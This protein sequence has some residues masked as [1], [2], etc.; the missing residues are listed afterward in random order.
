MQ[1][2]RRHAHV[3]AR[4]LTWV[5][6]LRYRVLMRGRVQFGKGFI[7]NHRFVVHGPGR[8][9]IGNGVNAWAHQEPTRLITTSRDAVIL[10]GDN[11]R[12]NGPTL[13]ARERVEVGENCILGS[14]VVFDSDYHSVHRDRRTTPHALVRTQPVRVGP[15]VWLAGQSAVLPGVSVGKD[16]VVGFR[17]VVT[18]DVPPGVVVAGNPAREVRQLP[19]VHDGRLDHRAPG[20][21]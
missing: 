3:L 20:E 8:V 15:N 4:V 19:A 12:L 13:L 17:A 11:A 10:I 5:I 2:I 6:V 18:R 16:S 14:T 21:L 9:I 1:V 7:C